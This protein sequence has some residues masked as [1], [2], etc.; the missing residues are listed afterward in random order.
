MVRGSFERLDHQH[1]FD[2]DG[3]GGTVMR[4]VFEFVSPFGP[5]GRLVDRWML[6][7]YLQ[8]FLEARNRIIKAIAESERPLP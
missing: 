4:D 7:N 3:C 1:F 2:D 5:I 6:A 8:Q